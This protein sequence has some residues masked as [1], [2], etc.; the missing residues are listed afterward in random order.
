MRG[1]TEPSRLGHG[2]DG[3]VTTVPKK[4]HSSVFL[5]KPLEVSE[6]KC[7]ESQPKSRKPGGKTQEVP[8]E[9]KQ[10]ISKKANEDTKKPGK[11]RISKNRWRDAIE[12][13]KVAELVKEYQNDPTVP[14]KDKYGE[15]KWKAIAAML[16]D[17][18]G[19]DRT[20]DSI[21]CKFAR[22]IR[23]SANYDE[24]SEKKKNPN[25]MQTSVESPENR[26]RKRQAKAQAK[27]QASGEPLSMRKKA[28][29]RSREEE[30]AQEDVI[31]RVNV[32]EGLA[33]RND[34]QGDVSNVREEDLDGDGFNEDN[35]V[36]SRNFERHLPPQFQQFDWS[37]RK[38]KGKRK[39]DENDDEQDSERHVQ[40]PRSS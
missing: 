39:R 9:S 17:R 26:K 31:G 40:M 21:K 38:N 12:E 29:R 32:D 6:N 27:A 35:V 19:Y 36:D 3:D 2:N 7:M 11:S 10:P 37:P 18:H 15:V 28:K 24:R 4:K 13:Q 22:K 16:L 30:E 34:Y 5:L 8:K 25:R 20:H 14:E 1:K 23:K 33:S